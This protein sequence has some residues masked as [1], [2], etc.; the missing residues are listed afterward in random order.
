MSLTLLPSTP[1][2]I[3][4]VTKRCKTMVTKRALASAGASI[5]PV[6]GLDPATDIGLLLQ[7]IPDINREFGLTPDQIEALNPRKKLMV[8]KA[9]V[10]L[11]GAMIGRVVTKELVVH[12][13][14]AVG[15]RI[16]HQTGVQTSAY[17]RAG[18]IRRARLRGDALS[19]A[20]AY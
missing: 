1:E 11:G 18:G 3:A 16:T 12:A 8:Y 20:D 5:V 6:P 15:V 14:K 4:E 13:L 10:A 2:D 19:G 9:V 17:R 7:L